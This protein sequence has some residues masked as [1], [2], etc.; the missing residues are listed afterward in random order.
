LW[1]FSL[2]PT[3]TALANKKENELAQG[4]SIKCRKGYGQGRKEVKVG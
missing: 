3:C 1:L 2:A 4:N